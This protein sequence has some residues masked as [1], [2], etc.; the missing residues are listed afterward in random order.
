[1]PKREQYEQKC[2]VRPLPEDRGSNRSDQH[3]LIDVK[4]PRPHGQQCVPSYKHT[5]YQCCG[6]VHD[7]DGSVDVSKPVQSSCYEIDSEGDKRHAQLQATR[8]MPVVMT[9][10][11]LVSCTWLM[12][13]FR[14][15][16]VFAFLAACC[17]Y[18]ARLNTNLTELHKNLGL[19]HLVEPVLDP[20]QSLDADCT[21]HYSWQLLQ[22]LCQSSRSTGMADRVDTQK[23][24]AIAAI[25][26]C[27]SRAHTIFQ[28]RH[29][30]R[31][32]LEVKANP[33]QGIVLGL[34]DVN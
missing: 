5:S 19:G 3:E 27:A 22:P 18:T 34:N 12:F 15:L 21:I 6:D 9:I 8:A 29:G 32:R 17:E 24:V 10:A 25:N 2:R 14:A 1:M 4:H 28:A 13:C 33:S 20:N 7:I 11:R 16:W 30:H 23:Q 31:A 26:L